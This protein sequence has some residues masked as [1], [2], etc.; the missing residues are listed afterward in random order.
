MLPQRA[1]GQTPNIPVATAGTTT[2]AVT[3]GASVTQG[4]AATPVATVTSGG[5][6]VT[7]G[8]VVLCN[9]NVVRCDGAAVLGTA[10]L[11]M[12]GTATIKR[13][14]G[15]GSDSLAAAYQPTG[16]FLGSASG[17]VALSV[18]GNGSYATTTAIA[19]TGV[20]GN[21]TLTGTVGGFGVNAPSGAMSPEHHRGERECGHGDAARLDGDAQLRQDEPDAALER[22]RSHRLLDGHGRLQRRW[23]PRSGLHESRL[24]RKARFALL[25]GPAMAACSHPPHRSPAPSLAAPYPTLVEVGDFNHDGILGLDRPE[26]KPRCH[27]GLP[28]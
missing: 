15:V 10:Q 5:T 27:P 6:P 12:A 7:S 19:A 18:T 11:T 8:A 9:A 24:E 4:S 3:Q 21:Y 13:I 23:D 1:M 17:P 25:W 20:P 2:L 16:Q 28:W 14:F 22:R 26:P